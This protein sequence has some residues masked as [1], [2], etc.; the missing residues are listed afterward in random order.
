MTE[1]NLSLTPEH[2]QL[3]AADCGHALT[4]DA[5]LNL[6]T[7]LDLL[8]RWN[9]VMNLVGT[10]NW[11]TTFRTL[12]IDSLYLADVM[13]NLPSSGPQSA[14]ESWDLGAGAGLP[15]IPLRMVWQEGAYWLIEARE[16]RALFLSTVLAH[17]ALPG[18]RVFN[19]RAERFMAQGRSAHCI[20]SRAFMPWEQL[21]P[22]VAPHL[23]EQGY[24]VLLTRQPLTPPAPWSVVAQIEYA[25][26]DDRRFII[27]LQKQQ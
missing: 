9:Q 26:R 22:F 10:R 8:T 2:L 21:L 16:K 3:V 25:I 13:R 19:G 7:Y 12:I 1:R 11:E 27:A 23:H 6:A 18:V 4:A 24:L 20:L 5:C 15:G 14:W 17:V